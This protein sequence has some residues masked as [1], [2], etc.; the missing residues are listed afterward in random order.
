MDLQTNKETKGQNEAAE[1]TQAFWRPRTSSYL[2]VEDA[3]QILQNIAGYFCQLDNWDRQSTAQADIRPETAKV[4]EIGLSNEQALTEFT[5][6]RTSCNQAPD[7][8]AA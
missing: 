7:S 1:Q 2:D 5:Q 3:R 8:F 4:T 6:E